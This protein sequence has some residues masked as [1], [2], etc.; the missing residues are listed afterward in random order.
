M[1]HK[2]KHC[3]NVIWARSSSNNMVRLFLSKFHERAYTYIL[4]TILM[5][6]TNVLPPSREILLP[7]KIQIQCS[8][9]DIFLSQREVMALLYQSLVLFR[10]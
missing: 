10:I 2:Q 9:R 1:K 3:S 5:D 7:K 4:V 6:S 8:P